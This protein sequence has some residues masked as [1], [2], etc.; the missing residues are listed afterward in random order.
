[1]T[2]ASSQN[3]MPKQIPAIPPGFGKGVIV[4][5]DQQHWVQIARSRDKGTD[6]YRRLFDA[7]EAGKIVVLLSA[8]N[9]AETWHR[10]EWQ[11]RWDLAR[12]MWDISRLA[13]LAPLH[14]LLPLE[15]A[16][17]VAS[18]GVTV[19]PSLN[20]WSPFGFGV[21]HAFDSITGRLT[22]VESLEDDGEPAIP[23]PVDQMDDDV[24]QLLSS[25]EVAYE[26]ASLAGFHGDMRKLTID[27]QTHHRL[28][29]AFA[30]SENDM[31]ELIKTRKP[32]IRLSTA[33]S[34]AA[35]FDIWDAL[36]LGLQYSGLDPNE[37]LSDLAASGGREA[38]EEFVCSLPAYGVFHRLRTLRFENPQKA[39]TQHDRLDILALAVAGAYAN[40]V[41]TEKL[42]SHLFGRIPGSAKK[43]F[44]TP[45]VEDA[46]EFL[47]I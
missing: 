27:G 30:K 35:L 2:A 15:T 26:W 44:V 29:T 31:R 24:K 20:S 42:W 5:L 12:S 17:A 8:S 19:D 36:C 34:G 47:Q 4:Y 46:L 14:A 43:P 23:V 38:V 25:G 1:M 7:V 33:L 16:E 22:L 41:V 45:S 9:Y 10:G 40:V 13:T 28:G 32:G 37:F 11:S 6:T 39:W 3:E 21:N 18:R